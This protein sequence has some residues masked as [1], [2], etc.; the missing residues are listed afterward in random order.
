MENKN[1]HRKNKGESESQGWVAIP[2]GI[3]NHK[4][5]KDSEQFTKREAYIVILLNVN[6]SLADVEIGDSDMTIRVKPLQSVRSLQTWGKMFNWQRYKVKRFLKH[7]EKSG[8]IITENLKV[9]TRITI[10][11]PNFVAAFSQRDRKKS[12]TASAIANATDNAT[13]NRLI[14]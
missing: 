3:F 2:R 1:T 11:D 6:H 14:Y 7:L 5:F 8:L 12:A 13:D 9:T 4:I 10:T